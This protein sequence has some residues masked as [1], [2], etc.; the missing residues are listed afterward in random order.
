MPSLI[1]VPKLRTLKRYG[2]TM[3]DW[4]ALL[5]KQ[6]GVCALCLTVPKCKML[7]VDHEH[8]RGFRKMK[9]V[10][11]RK[12]VRGLLCAHCNHRLVNRYITL[13]VIKSI[14]SYLQRYESI[15]RTNEVVV[16]NAR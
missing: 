4:R 10:D 2:L 3:A 1:R 9:P 11:R 12:F 5:K 7:C 14:E 15:R 8:I 13:A 6:N 16:S